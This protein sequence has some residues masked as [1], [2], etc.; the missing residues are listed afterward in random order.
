MILTAQLIL[1]ALAMQ[2]ATSGVQA[3]A[4]DPVSRQPLAALVSPNDYPAQAIAT[5]QSGTVRFRLDVGANG[6]VEGCTILRSSRSSILDASTCR[7]M[8]SRARFT[9]ARDLNGQTVAG[10]IEDEISWTL[11]GTGTADRPPPRLYEL[12]KIYTACTMGD[13]ARRAVSTMN[14]NVIADATFATCAEIEPLLLAQMTLANRA[15]MV[16]A[17]AMRQLK[18]RLRTQL[19]AQVGAMRR[20]L[21]A[22]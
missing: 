2:S 3:I 19:A 5:R 18:L 14:V 8:R 9:P 20:N 21:T 10:R 1:A 13:A 11:P 22:R 6:R 12:I 4:S 17:E 15:N 16:P 7:L